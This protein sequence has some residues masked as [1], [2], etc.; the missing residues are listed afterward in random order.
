ML[1][2]NKFF[3]FF[4]LKLLLVKIKPYCSQSAF[5]L[6]IFE[7]LSV[8]P[9]NLVKMAKSVLTLQVDGNKQG[10]VS[11]EIPKLRLGVSFICI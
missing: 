6:V 5:A 10:L 8:S 2:V 9:E 1:H 3:F 4:I 11:L 7:L